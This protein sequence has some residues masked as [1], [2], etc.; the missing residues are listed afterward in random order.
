MDRYYD[1]T[2]IDEKYGIIRWNTTQKGIRDSILEKW[3]LGSLLL[4]QLCESLE[5]LCGVC[6]QSSHFDYRYSGALHDNEKLCQ[7]KIT[8]VIAYQDH[9]S[10]TVQTS[11]TSIAKFPHYCIIIHTMVK[12]FE[13]GKK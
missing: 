6:S 12:L 2:N 11:N 3:I 13:I 9:K 1:Q 4:M 8:F 7:A 5:E 10:Q